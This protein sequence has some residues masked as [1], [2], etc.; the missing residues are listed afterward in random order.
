MARH[1]GSAR[2]RTKLWSFHTTSFDRVGTAR[3]K[4]APLSR[5]RNIGGLGSKESSGV[6]PY[7]LSDGIGNGRRT[8]QRNGVGMAWAGRHVSAIPELDHATPIQDDDGVSHATHDGEVVRDEEIAEMAFTLLLREQVE[9]LRLD[10]Q[11]ERAH[12]FVA[13]HKIGAGDHRASNGDSLALATRKLRRISVSHIGA[14]S[15]LFERGDDCGLAIPIEMPT[16]DQKWL[17]HG[18]PDGP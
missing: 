15:N 3:G 9:Y 2:R 7:R 17:D 5:Y 13:D 6:T 10:R 1:D 8:E 18:L 11:I 14:Q 4:A 16:S 12:R